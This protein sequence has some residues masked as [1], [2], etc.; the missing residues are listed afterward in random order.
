M[1][2]LN[3]GQQRVFDLVKQGENIFCSGV[4]GTGK[5]YLIN[6]IRKEFG[7][8]TL[9][10][11][12]T[13]TSAL[14]IGGSTVHSGMS[15]PTG[16][17]TVGDLKKVSQ[18]VSQ[19][20][21]TNHIQRIVID[22]ASMLTPGAVY[23]F[24]RRLARFQKKTRVR[25]ERKLQVIF[26]CDMGQ[27]G[28][29]MNHKEKVLALQDYKTD[30]FYKMRQFEELNFN[31]VE[32]TQVLRQKDKE[33]KKMLGLIRQGKGSYK[34]VRGKKV[35]EIND[36][37]KRAVDYFN[38]KCYKYPLP[39]GVP[40]LATR[41]K[42]VDLYNNKVFNQNNNECF[43]YSASLTGS[44]KEKEAPVDIDLHLKEGLHVII[45]KNDM[46]GQYV[47]GS[48]GVVTQMTCDG[49]TVKLDN[50]FEEPMLEPADWSKK[51]YTLEKNED[52]VEELVQYTAGRFS[53]IPI[54][55]CS[56]ISV[57]RSQ[58]Q[59]LEAVIVDL[60]NGAGWA[61]GLTYVALSRCTTVEGISLKTPIKYTDV[62][63]DREALEWLDMKLEESRIKN[64]WSIIEDE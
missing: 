56:A 31:F 27:L 7:H 36:E 52:G 24:C 18:K 44:F 47:N 13:G 62:V 26:F 23:S 33:M 11:S 41:N 45:V 46:E 17:P 55:Q 3:Q 58:G 53:Q 35:F 61:T 32:L 6:M 21:S 40:I 60:G 19:L 51:D 34:N 39:E 25:R 49:V 16:H 30:K 48:T 28:A 5:S 4:G 38:T 37:T 22:E 63:A 29:I 54:K 59:T 14:N 1:S 50:T 10:L 2:K 9:F 12:T 15:I 57:H 43:V 8:E 42:E 64:G 20:F